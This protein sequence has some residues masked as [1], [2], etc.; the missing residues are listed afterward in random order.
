MDSPVVLAKIDSLSDYNFYASKQKIIIT[1][2]LR[3]ID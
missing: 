1:L 2:A 3:E